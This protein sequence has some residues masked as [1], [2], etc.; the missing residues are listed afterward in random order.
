M[1]SG[2]NCA[3]VFAGGWWFNQCLSSNLNG[4]YIAGGQHSENPSTGV[5]WKD[6]RGV[7]YSLKCTEM[8]MRPKS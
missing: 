5:L 1:D 6:F 7:Q 8:K 4:Q 3:D 2:R